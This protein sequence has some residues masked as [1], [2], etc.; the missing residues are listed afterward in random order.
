[1]KEKKEGRKNNSRNLTLGM[2]NTL[3]PC[4]PDEVVFNYSSVRILH[5]LRT[6]LAF[7]SDFALLPCKINLF[8]YYYPFEKLAK[9]LS[10]KTCRDFELSTDEV[11]Y[12]SSKFYFESNK[13]PYS[14][15]IIVESFE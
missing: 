13:F 14:I 3:E 4:N 12:V 2:H 5:E 9:N 1:M 10:D 6:L 7:G 15:Y 8:S 11:R